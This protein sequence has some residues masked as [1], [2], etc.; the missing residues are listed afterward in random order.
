M[1]NDLT[2]D[3][4]RAHDLLEKGKTCPY[5]NP[6][7]NAE[8]LHCDDW[9]DEHGEL[10]AEEQWQVYRLFTSFVEAIEELRATIK[11]DEQTIAHN[12]ATIEMQTATIQCL[13]IL[14]HQSF[15]K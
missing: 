1:D 6:D 4:K 10:T 12:I 13:Q 15:D 9:A 8:C 11:V 5:Y 2:N 3:L 7:H 14:L